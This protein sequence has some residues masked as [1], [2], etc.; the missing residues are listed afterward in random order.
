MPT[1]NTPTMETPAMDTPTMDTPAT[2]TT[3]MDTPALAVVVGQHGELC[4][5][6]VHERE[7][8]WQWQLLV[9]SSGSSTFWLEKDI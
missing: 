8:S 7:P 1:V 6:L 2:D 9:V 5:L 4:S 3:T